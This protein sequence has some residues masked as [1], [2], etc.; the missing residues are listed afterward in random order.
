M[1]KDKQQGCAADPCPPLTSFLAGLGRGP[2]VVQL[3]SRGNGVIVIRLVRQ[4]STNRR[5]RP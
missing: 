5:R 4:R 2:P 3:E 1:S